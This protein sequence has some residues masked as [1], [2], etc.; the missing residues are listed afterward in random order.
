MAVNATIGSRIS[1]L[2]GSSYATI[3]NLSYKDLIYNA[4]NEV[5][6]MMST[7]NLLK[8]SG[9]PSETTNLNYYHI[10]D[11]KILSVTRIDADSGGIQ[12]ECKGMSIGD[13]AKAEDSTSILAATAYSPVYT[14]VA[15]ADNSY[16]KW[17]PATNASGQT[18]LVYYFSYAL[19]STDL[20]QITTSTLNSTHKLPGE[21]IHAIV[22][23]ACVNI[24]TAY[25]SEQIQDEEDME[26]MGMINTQINH[27]DKLFLNEMQR[28]MDKNREATGE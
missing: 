1:D 18:G 16:I 14:I 11:K 13:F 25:L 2:I 5:A 3:P 9:E 22:L 8:Y 6:D 15:S 17:A 20:T 23:K 7:E 28:F 27:F 12:R 10:E 4:F 21:S 19:G 24:L 26:L